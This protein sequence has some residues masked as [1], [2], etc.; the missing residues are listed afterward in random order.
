[1]YASISCT[2]FHAS[3][4]FMHKF[5]RKKKKVDLCFF[6]LPGENLSSID[7]QPVFKNNFADAVCVD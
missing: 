4:A 1:M 5:R 3:F 7:V 2:L 6:E